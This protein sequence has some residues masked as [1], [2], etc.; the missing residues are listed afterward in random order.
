MHGLRASVVGVGLLTAGLACGQTIDWIG[1]G[2][3]ACSHDGRVVAGSVSGLS[4]YWTR[5]TGAVIFGQDSGFSFGNRARAVSGDGSV[6]AGINSPSGGPRDNAY[7]WT[8][9]GAYESIGR[10]D[11]YASTRLSAAD[12][13]GETL[14]GYSET[15]QTNTAQAWVWTRGAGLRGIGYT[16]GGAAG[17]SQALGVSADGSMV[18]GFSGGS[19]FTDAFTWTASEGMTRLPTL[20]GEADTDLEAHGVSPNGR[21]IVGTVQSGASTLG[22][23]WTDRTP[24]RLVTPVGYDDIIPTSVA[25]NGIV[26]GEAYRGSSAATAFVWSPGEGPM[27]MSDYLRG[28]GVEIPAGSLVGGDFGVSGDGTTF[29]GSITGVGAFVATIPAPATTLLLLAACLARRQRTSGR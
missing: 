28:F 12:F 17:Y 21:R 13:T 9:P 1:M 25:D 10:L 26:V 6:F 8:G 23:L 11:Q 18:V 5:S 7:R 22:C 24:T 2:P 16:R 3:A 19:L 29:Y 4:S 20:P 14:V 27:L 15:L